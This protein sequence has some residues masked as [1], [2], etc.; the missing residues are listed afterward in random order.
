MADNQIVIKLRIDDKGNLK[1]ASSQTEQLSRSTDKAARSTDKLQ[2]SRDKYNRTEKGVASISS[3]STKNFSKMQQSID[4]GGGSGGLVRAYALL[5]A[6]V[7]ALTAAFGVLSRGSEVQVLIASIEQLE[8]VSGKSITQVGRDLQA[9]SGFSLDLASSLRSVSLATSAGFNAKQ[10]EELGRV[11]KNASVSLGRDLADG[12]DRIFRGVIKVEPELLDEIGLFVRVNEAASK[13]AADLGISVSSLTD[14]QKRQAFANE[15]LEQGRKKFQAFEDVEVSPLNQLAASLQDIANN[16]IGVLLERVNPVLKFFQENQQFLAVA[17]G[18][19]VTVLLRQAIPALGSFAI[20]ARKRAQEAS[21]AFKNTQQEIKESLEGPREKSINKALEKEKQITAEIERRQQR[22]AGSVATG[23]RGQA[24]GGAEAARLRKE[25]DG[26]KNLTKRKDLLGKLEKR[27]ALSRRGASTASRAAIDKEV[28]LIQKQI[29]ETERLAKTEERRKKLQAT[30]ASGNPL[31]GSP[32]A[33]QQRE[34]EIGLIKSQRVEA[35]SG[36]LA[37]EGLSGGI[38]ALGSETKKSFNELK[39]FGT[40]TRIAGAAAVAAQGSFLVLG[41]AVSKITA[42]LGPL[43]IAL[44]VLGP[45][46]TVVAKAIGI[47]SK[48]QKEYIKQLKEINELQDTFN[49]KIN[50]ANT[51]L[52]KN[53]D[54]ISFTGR[55]DAISASINAQSELVAKTLELVEA[56]KALREQRLID[57]LGTFG[58]DRR[59]AELDK[60][61]QESFQKVFEQASDEFIIGAFGEANLKQFRALQKARDDALKEQRVIDPTGTTGFADDAFGNRNSPAAKLFRTLNETADE[62]AK[63]FKGILRDSEGLTEQSNNFIKNLEEQVKASE[64]MKSAIDGATDSLRSFRQKFVTTTDIDKPLA[65]ISQVLSSLGVVDER[66]GKSEQFALK[67][68]ED[69]VA[70]EKI[71]KEEAE[72]RIKGILNGENAILDLLT[73]QERN[74]LKALDAD[75][76]RLSVNRE[77]TEEAREF[78]NIMLKVEKR[79]TKQQIGLILNKDEIALNTNAMKLFK[80]AID[81]SAN[82]A[83]FASS[84]RM[85]NMELEK[86]AAQDTLDNALTLTKLDE[87]EIE[88]RAKMRR[89]DLMKDTE[90]LNDSQDILAAIRAL[91]NLKLAEIKEELELKTEIFRIEES[92]LK[93]ENQVFDAQLKLNKELQ[94]QEKLEANI[95]SL[96]TSGRELN[97]GEK[98]ALQ[99]KGFLESSELEDKKLKNEQTIATIKADILEFELQAMQDRFITELR[100]ADIKLATEKN[101]SDKQKESQKRVRQMLAEEETNGAAGFEKLRANIA[102]LTAKSTNDTLIQLQNVEKFVGDIFKV[103]ET[104]GQKFIDGALGRTELFKGEPGQSPIEQL[105]ARRA[106]QLREQEGPL[107]PAQQ[108]ELEGIDSERTLKSL[109]RTALI[110]EFNNGLELMKENLKDLGPDGAAGTA[111]LTFGQTLSSSFKTFTEGTAEEKVA[112]VGAI[113]GSLAQAMAAASE[114]RIAGIEREI[115]AERKRDGKSKESV[116]KIKALEAQKE[117]MAKKAFE[118]NKKMQIA[119]TIINTATAAMGAY[120]SMAA[121][122][123]PAAIAAATMISA[124]G[125]ASVAMIARQQYE[126]SGG[127]ETSTAAPTNVNIG[128]R[129]NEVDV[130]RQASRGELAFLRGERG[131]GSIDNFRP[132]ASGRRGYAHGSEGVVVGERGPEVITPSMPVDIIP[133]DQINRTSTNVNFTIHAVDAAGLEQTLQSQRGNII[134]MIREAANGYGENF[135]EQVD[136]D[137]LDTTGGSY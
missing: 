56:E 71:K 100:I 4:G 107:S 116:Q 48:E 62:T 18:G 109:E 137:T 38:S 46:Y 64:N 115:E 129:G 121:I 73:Q 89:E 37:I 20:N 126:G 50:N 55:A 118:R 59:G 29:K 40:G 13:Y 133:N 119:T 132:A 26:T 53:N 63:F 83:Q 30:P 25:I 60:E 11:A 110:A 31:A 98:L 102:T 34:T 88:K 124:I 44:A 52:A 58:L 6:N 94:K 108:E 117:M 47:T 79:L 12:L 111:L 91:E 14:F 33:R 45:I 23:A 32:L 114:A 127:G 65:S 113:V 130:S 92:L 22:L 66:L 5:A 82:S 27:L 28:K 2:K 128:A 96:R 67:N 43:T 97:E 41:E 15:A 99:L 136:I 17:F 1:K 21:A 78:F 68:L 19:I 36:K 135:L 123:V 125:A 24:L 81:S 69:G 104:A 103:P 10:I 16:A 39:K 77:L 61:L 93:M 122:S 70:F 74:S 90:F 120:A 84:L 86:Q 54:E 134:G 95:K 80:N 8:I 57:G 7:F 51:Q 106:Q 112:A 87:K 131:T 35:I 105:L 42:F 9:A 85:R 76:F 72:N 75:T 49:K 101:L 3:N